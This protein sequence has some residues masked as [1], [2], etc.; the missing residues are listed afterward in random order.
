MDSTIK[1]EEMDSTT[2]TKVMVSTTKTKWGIQYSSPQQ[3]VYLSRN[4][5]RHSRWYI[6]TE[7]TDRGKNT[8]P[9]SCSENI[10]KPR[11]RICEKNKCGVDT[12]KDFSLL[13]MPSLSFDPFLTTSFLKRS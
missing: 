12:P 8:S 3:S 4:H 5:V 7:Y 9:F 10:Q 1:T 2:K 6:D 11:S 13:F